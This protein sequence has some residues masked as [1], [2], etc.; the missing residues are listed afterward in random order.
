MDRV[1][2][3]GRST[4]WRERLRHLYHDEGTIPRRFRY[5]LVAFDI[6]VIADFLVIAAH[7]GRFETRLLDI[8][9]GVLII[10]EF[11]ARL[12]AEEGRWRYLRSTATIAD[13]LVI[14]S[15]FLPAFFDNLGFLRVARALRV[16]R[17]YRL[18]A[19]LRQDLPWFK[20]NEDVVFRSANLVVFIFVVTSVVFVTQNDVNPAIR[21]YLDA[22]YFT[23]TTLTTTGF[24]DITLVGPGGRLLAV[25]VM[26]VGVSLFLRLLQAIFRPTKVR[27]ECEDCGLFMHDIDAVHCKHCGN[28]LRI[29]NDGEV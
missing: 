27:Y 11:A 9:L 25:V 15:L 21:N 18:A 7:P 26:I 8:V 3:P 4:G 24:G 1:V 20:A 14:V 2:A 6:V 17:S 5:A 12:Y 22:L 13:V 19:D 16:L 28:M 10:I 29:R 23:I